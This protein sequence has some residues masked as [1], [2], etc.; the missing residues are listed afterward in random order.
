MRFYALTLLQ[1]MIVESLY[2]SHR[3]LTYIKTRTW[4]LQHLTSD[5]WLLMVVYILHLLLSIV[6]VR[7][8]V[9]THKYE[10]L[11]QDKVKLYLAL[12]LT[13]QKWNISFILQQC[14]DN[15]RTIKNVRTAQKCDVSIKDSNSVTINPYHK[16]WCM[17]RI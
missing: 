14:C 10:I 4:P 17:S 6:I 3:S 2:N 15:I 7:S 11:Q 16:R 13:Y 12:S 9:V 5:L 8:S 1:F